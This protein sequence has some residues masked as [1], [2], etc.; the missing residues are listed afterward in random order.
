MGIKY[1]GRVVWARGAS[2]RTGPSADSPTVN[3][4]P[5][6]TPIQGITVNIEQAAMNSRGV[7]MFKVDHFDGRM[8][9]PLVDTIDPYTDPRV[10]F[11]TTITDTK[12]ESGYRY[13]VS[14]SMMARTCGPIDSQ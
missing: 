13:V 3:T 4:L 12:V 1:E 8:P 9:A 6:D 14:H 10:F 7:K 11:A 5:V 2:E